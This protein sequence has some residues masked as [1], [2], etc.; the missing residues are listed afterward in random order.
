MRIMEE[1]L[2]LK[3]YTD[4]H[5]NGTNRSYWAKFFNQISEALHE[6]NRAYLHSSFNEN[7]PI[8]EYYSRRKNRFVR[9]MQYNPENEIINEGRFKTQ[10][11]YTAWIDKRT[12]QD[13]LPPVPELVVCLL[14][15]KDNVKSAKHLIWT[16]MFEDQKRVT[17]L[18]E[19]IYQSQER[20]DEEV[21]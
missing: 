17:S 6:T 21:R 2:F 13:G 19:N 16:W 15:T 4:Y 10:R 7:M 3:T 1:I 8:Y 12:I 9:V 5:V 11:F 14:M 20:L 18:I